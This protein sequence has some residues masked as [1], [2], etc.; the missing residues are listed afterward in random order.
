MPVYILLTHLSP[1]AV[2]SPKDLERLER[3]VSNKIKAECPKVKWLDNYAVLGPYDY[4][5]IFEAPDEVTAAKVVMI[6]R[7]FGH[8]STETWTAIR[9]DRFKDLAR[10]VA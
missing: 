3:E 6:I 7:S 4:V 9:W 8:A 2:K 5:D 10:E 1:E